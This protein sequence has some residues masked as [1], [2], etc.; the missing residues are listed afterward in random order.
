ML[1]KCI[2]N[3]YLLFLLPQENIY[4][5]SARASTRKIS[6]EEKQKGQNIRLSVEWN[7]IKSSYRNP[8][9]C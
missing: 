1:F 9:Q 5:K 4:S 7:Q 6:F 3:D 8:S 2:P